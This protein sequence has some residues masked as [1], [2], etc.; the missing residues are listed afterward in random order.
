MLISSM[1]HLELRFL[2]RPKPN[3]SRRGRFV[4]DGEEGG[5]TSMMR[6]QELGLRYTGVQIKVKVV[7]PAEI[8]RATPGEAGEAED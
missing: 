6:R 4:E 2:I 1:V 5:P 7:F 8:G 3:K